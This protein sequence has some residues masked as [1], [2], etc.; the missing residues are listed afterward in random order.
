MRKI[1]MG[2]FLMGISFCVFAQNGVIRESSGTVEVKK[3]GAAGY[4]PAKAGDT[5]SQDTVIYTGLRSTALVEVGSTVIAVRPLT[6]LTLTEI[7]A[8][9]G[10]E[11]LNM[12]LQAG[13][14]RVDVNPPA[15][16]RATMSINSPIATASVRG[17]SF[18]FDTRNLR[19]EKGTVLFKGN[20]GYTI[21]AGAG[22][23]SMVGR[24]GTASAPQSGAG[25]QASSPVGSDL[26]A[27]NTS[28]E[29]MRSSG[30]NYGPG[31][32]GIGVGY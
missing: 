29:S 28:Q 20:R 23:T 24:N 6:R 16:S 27:G 5:V 18:Y 11:T 25:Y 14:V 9:V 15:G 8:S 7:R 21:Q 32:I 22:T 30:G 26:S 17:T 3:A 12:S 4:V 1:I 13:R 31:T 19:V 10:E 2:L